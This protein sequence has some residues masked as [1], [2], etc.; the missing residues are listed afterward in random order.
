L[1]PYEDNVIQLLSTVRSI[2]K[3]EK[4]FCGS[5]EGTLTQQIAVGHTIRI[6]GLPH[7]QMYCYET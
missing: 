7:V 2:H 5:L 1:A 3:V 4:Q 6:V